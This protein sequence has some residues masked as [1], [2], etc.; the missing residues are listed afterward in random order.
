MA[1]DYE[2]DFITFFTQLAAVGAKF[3]KD[4]YLVPIETIAPRL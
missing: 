2:V 3:D 1:A 4:A